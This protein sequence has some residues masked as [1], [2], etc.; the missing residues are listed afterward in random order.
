VTRPT[1]EVR[2]QVIQRAGNRCEYCH[3]HQDDS[4]SRH[5]V[6]HVIAEKHGGKTTLENLALSCLPCNR[7]KSSDIGALDP[8]SGLFV[9]L[10]DPRHQIWSGHFHFV[11][12]SIM[13][14]TPEARATVEFLQLNS[15][16]RLQE[17]A[18]LVRIGRL[19]P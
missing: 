7:R 16:E 19:L 6:D 2:R 4:A 15:P 8:E 14:L 1:A 11:S 18:E 5:Q 12:T 3:I 13:G 9:R 17:R 10:F